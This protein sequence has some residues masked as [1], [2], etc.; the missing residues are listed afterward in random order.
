MTEVEI[1]TDGA[2]SGN[3]GPGGFCAILLH[4]GNEKVITGAY[5]ETTNN[6][7]EVLAA[8]EGLSALKRRVKVK[9]YSDS[10]YLVNAIEQ[11]WLDGW[12]RNGWKTADGK[13]VKNRDLWERLD[14]LLAAHDVVFIKVKG[15]SD[16][17]YN[18][19]CDKEAR[20]AIKALLDEKV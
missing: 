4:A 9:L 1:Y 10:A 12:K 14:K 16:N 13:E 11:H 7:M 8:V 19:R 5:K 18:N 15:H 2:C 6:R 3:P 17:E 20:A